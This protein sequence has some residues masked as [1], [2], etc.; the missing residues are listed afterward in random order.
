MIVYKL[1]KESLLIKYWSVYLKQPL[2]ET[3]ELFKDANKL[4]PALPA[5]NT[6]K[7][8]FP[9]LWGPTS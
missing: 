6:G 5:N 4:S 2:W 8:Q 1:T 9:S 7:K 3:N